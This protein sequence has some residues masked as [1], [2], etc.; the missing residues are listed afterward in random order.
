MSRRLRTYEADDITVTW[1]A[2]RCIHAAACVRGLPDVFDPDRQPWVDPAAAPADE[3]ARV[4]QRCP[5]GALQYER[6]DGGPEE[7]PVGR[8]EARLGVDG[9]VF[10]RG[11]LCI[12]I[13]GGDVIRDTR[14][15]LCRCGASADKPFCDGSH[16]EAGFSDPGLIQG[17]RLVPL[18]DEETAQVTLTCAENGPVLVR[19][20]LRIEANDGT[21]VE[22]EKGA[23]CRCGL[24]GTKPFCD[25]SHAR[26]A[27][28]A[29][30]S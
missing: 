1:D 15:A 6:H 17:G 14:A 2:R 9:P 26:E 16:V 28:E 24:S 13:P 8:A 19:G 30:G 18:P 3:I 11:D 25:G 27:F 5:T 10:V 7:K 29:P 23:L 4:I 20:S 12:E 21:V 22:G